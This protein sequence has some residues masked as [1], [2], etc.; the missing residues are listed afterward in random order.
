[1]KGKLLAAAMLSVLAV[2]C[3]QTDVID[4]AKSAISFEPQNAKL[5]RA[6]TD[7]PLTSKFAA[8]AYQ[9]GTT[10]IYDGMSGIE[11]SN[12]GTATAPIWKNATTLHYWPGTALDFFAVS[13]SSVSSKVTIT[14]SATTGDVD[15]AI[16]DYAVPAAANEDLMLADK[17]TKSEGSVPTVFN[18]L[19]SAIVIT[20]KNTS[21]D[22]H[23]AVKINSITTTDNILTTGSYSS[24]TGLWK[25]GATA[26]AAYSNTSLNLTLTAKAQNCG[27]AWIVMPQTLTNNV[28]KVTVNYTMSGVTTSKTF[29]LYQTSVQSWAPNQRVTYNLVFTG[30]EITFTPSITAWTETAVTL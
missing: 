12:T 23:A 28:Q 13:P 17:A 7:Y 22:T 18:H 26:K 30:N 15:V 29:N 24:K 2:G 3:S 11:I 1:M 4:S 10:T 27:N 8:W 14:N 19:L 9:T 21:T 20:A 6:D 5:S 25:V 16:A